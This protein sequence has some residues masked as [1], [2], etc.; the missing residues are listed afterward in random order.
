MGAPKAPGIGSFG[1][2]GQV[3]GGMFLVKVY[4]MLPK[5]ESHRRPWVNWSPETF[6]PNGILGMNLELEWIL[7]DCGDGC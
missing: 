2:W 3:W 5:E 6:N 1:V 4:N 7:N